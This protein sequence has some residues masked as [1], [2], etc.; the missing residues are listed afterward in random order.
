MSLRLH[1][2][3]IVTPQDTITD[4][5]LGNALGVDENVDSVMNMLHRYNPSDWWVQRS[6]GSLVDYG[7]AVLL[8]R[9]VENVTGASVL[10]EPE[11]ITLTAEVV[12]YEID[13]ILTWLKEVQDHVGAVLK[14]EDLDGHDEDGTCVEC[15]DLFPEQGDLREL[16]GEDAFPS[17]VTLVEALGKLLAGVKNG[18]IYFEEI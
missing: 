3:C 2:S 14:E 16:S 7:E 5:R 11:S 12:H 17:V 10:Y 8:Q 15:R 13:R 1:L 18:S 6:L 9:A 4:R